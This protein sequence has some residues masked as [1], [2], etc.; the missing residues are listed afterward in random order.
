MIDYL[1]LVGLS[2]IDSLSV[3]TLVIPL[4]LII[5]WQAM[6]TAHYTTY[7]T[8]IVCAYFMIG[9]ALFMGLGWVIA[10]FSQVT[11]MAWFRWI[12]LVLGVA[13]VLFGVLSPNP[14]RR[15]VEEI[16]AARS[17]QVQSKRGKNVGLLSMVV[18]ALGAAVVESATMLPYLAALGIIQSQEIPF[19]AQLVVLALYCMVMALPAISLGVAVKVLGNRVFERILGVLPRLEY[20]A[21]ITLLWIAA[22][23]GANIAHRSAIQLGLL[24]WG[25]LF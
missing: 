5:K 3:G 13:L 10:A 8:T 11:A 23:V 18:L 1:L 24:S 19:V 17:V 9:C 14:T 7:L 20:E 21:K 6:K 25:P 12:L 2:L 15:S 4:V 22:I 16:V